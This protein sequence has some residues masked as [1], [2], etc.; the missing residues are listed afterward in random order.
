M[1]HFIVEL[2]DDERTL[3]V[4]AIGEFS[5]NPLY[6]DLVGKLVN[7]ANESDLQAEN[8]ALRRQLDEQWDYNHAEHCGCETPDGER[9]HWPRPVLLGGDPDR[10]RTYQ[11]EQA[12]EPR[13]PIDGEG[14]SPNG[15]NGTSDR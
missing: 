11:D 4:G 5:D 14:T 6:M 12:T 13:W 15:G 10:Y 1:T 9:C 7:E 2:T 8:V 3:I